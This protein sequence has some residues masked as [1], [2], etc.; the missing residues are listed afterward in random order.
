MEVMEAVESGTLLHALRVQLKRRVS[1]RRG[2]DYNEVLQAIQ[3]KS[4][5][6]PRNCVTP[7][8]CKLLSEQ[9]FGFR[10][11]NVVECRVF[12]SH[13]PSDEVQNEF[14]IRGSTPVSANDWGKN[15]AAVAVL[16]EFA[17]YWASLI[18]LRAVQLRVELPCTIVVLFVDSFLSF[19]QSFPGNSR[20]VVVV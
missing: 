5:P 3:K 11:A 14:E 6:S 12:A 19:L 20:G 13:F 8:A 2:G 1:A 9:G 7:F 10:K 15:T 18:L 16:I 4:R 17:L